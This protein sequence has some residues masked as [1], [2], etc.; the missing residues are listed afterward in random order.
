MIVSEVVAKTL[1]VC[2]LVGA[3][4]IAI[5]EITRKKKNNTKP[6][7]KT[8]TAEENNNVQECKVIPRTSFSVDSEKL[9]KM[10][11]EASFPENKVK[12]FVAAIKEQ[13]APEHETVR[14]ETV[15]DDTVKAASFTVIKE[16]KMTQ[17]NFGKN[18][19]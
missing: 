9:E 2:G 8:E 3:G 17:P 4:T 19:K 6:L 14:A 7:Q 13:A 10:L 5:N 1:G 18:N 16:P 15:E 11:V 12:D